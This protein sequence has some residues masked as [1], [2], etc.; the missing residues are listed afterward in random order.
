MQVI[1]SPRVESTTGPGDG[2]LPVIFPNLV[3]DNVIS[4]QQLSKLAVSPNNNSLL[5]VPVIAVLEGPS[6]S[7]Q[8]FC[9]Y[10][11][12]KKNIGIRQKET[13]PNRCTPKEK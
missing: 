10:E 13:I 12:K 11:Q 8:I 1:A 4:L 3:C 6:V 2:K 9:N 7:G 5:S